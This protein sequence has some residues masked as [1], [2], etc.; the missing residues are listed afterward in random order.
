MNGLYLYPPTWLHGIPAGIKLLA[1]AAL[2]IVL[3]NISQALFLLAGLAAVFA[4]YLFSGISLVQRLKLLRPLWPVMLMIFAGQ[5]Y[6]AGFDAGVASVARL[7]LMILLADLVTLS[8]PMQDMMDAFAK[9]FAPL[10][11]TGLN[12]KRLSFGVALVIRFVPVL[13]DL[14]RQQEEAW[15]ARTGKRAGWKLIAPFLANVMRM[16]DRTAEALDARGFGNGRTSR[17]TERKS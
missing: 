17:S 9:V 2:S 12:I 6:A 7:A 16:A 10:S 11:F 3:I 13:L 15:R 4:I 14:W 5:T 1:L 8:T